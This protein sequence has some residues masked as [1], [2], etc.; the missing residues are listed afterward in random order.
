M[1]YDQIDI[2]IPLP[3]DCGNDH[4]ELKKLFNT[5]L[6]ILER[7]IKLYS[8]SPYYHIDTEVTEKR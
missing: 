7:Y 3:K 8:N 5:P 4:Q 6:E 2:K 1:P